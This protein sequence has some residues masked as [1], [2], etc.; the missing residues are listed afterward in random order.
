MIDPLMRPHN[1]GLKKGLIL[2]YTF[3]DIQ[4]NTVKDVAGN[5]DASI[6]NTDLVP[7]VIG[8]GVKFRGQQLSRVRTNDKVVIGNVFTLSF[9]IKTQK[10]LKQWH[11]SNR[12]GFGFHVPYSFF[13]ICQYPNNLCC[14]LM[15]NSGDRIVLDFIQKENIDENKYYHLILSCDGDK[16][17]GKVDN[18]QVFEGSIPFDYTMVDN[19]IEIGANNS[20]NYTS[21]AS[22]DMVY[23]WNRIL[24]DEEQ[25]EL[26][27]NGNGL[28]IK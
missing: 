3:D 12:F 13:Q 5:Y 7:G 16:I 19:Y 23:L 24:T 6:S 18:Q 14:F 9:W 10:N 2:G 25:S 28:I 17:Y 22:M 21:K 15:K 26:Y 27:N 4:G 8:D 20:P 1:N 11:I